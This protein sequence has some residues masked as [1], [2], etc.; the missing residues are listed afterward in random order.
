MN[1]DIIKTNL[2]RRVK[3]AKIFYFKKTAKK[4]THLVLI[5][6]K[7]ICK[8]IREYIQVATVRTIKSV[9]H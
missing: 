2:T 6:G 9:K 7:L 3:P 4:F 8:K 1:I 5:P